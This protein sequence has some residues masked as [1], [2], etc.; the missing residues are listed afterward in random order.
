MGPPWP[1]G[2]GEWLELTLFWIG[3]VVV[4]TV[5]VV[6]LPKRT[7]TRKQVVVRLQGWRDWPEVR[8]IM[9]ALP[10]ELLWEVAQFPLYTVWHQ[11]DWGTFS[12]GWPIALWAT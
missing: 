10:L 7:P 6:S 8:L 3:A 5:L 9:L 12:S 1:M 2:P 11:N 4:M